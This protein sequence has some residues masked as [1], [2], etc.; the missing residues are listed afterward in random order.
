MFMESYPSS[1]LILIF[2]P[3][4]LI[5]L[6]KVRSKTQLKSTFLLLV[7]VPPVFCQLHFQFNLCKQF[8]MST[9]K[10][11]LK[12]EAEL[13]ISWFQ[14]LQ[15]AS[16]LLNEKHVLISNNWVEMWPFAKES[17]YVVG[18]KS[19]HAFITGMMLRHLEFQIKLVA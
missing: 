9:G 10:E 11:L 7:C 8:Q 17:L 13:L 1:K 4:L 19:C 16:G 5:L 2:S 18:L 3:W 15:L 14:T 12:E 6:V